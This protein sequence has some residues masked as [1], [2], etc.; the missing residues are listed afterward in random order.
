MQKYSMIDISYF[1]GCSMATTAHEN[2][3]SLL[4]SCTKMGVNLI[5][6]DDWNCCG[7]SSAHSVDSKLFIKLVSRN[8]AIAPPGRP[9][10]APCPSCVLRLR[11]AFHHIKHDENEQKDF[12]D[13]WGKPFNPKLEILNVIEIPNL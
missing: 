10:L 8:L 5:E 13:M 4:E 7:S 12:E 11:E 3:Q 1:P 6:L 9:L 2:N